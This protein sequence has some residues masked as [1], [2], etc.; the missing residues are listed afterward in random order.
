MEKTQNRVGLDNTL[1]WQGLVS[2]SNLDSFVAGPVNR[3]TI[4]HPHDPRP[5]LHNSGPTSRTPRPSS[6]LAPSNSQDSPFTPTT[7]PAYTNPMMEPPLTS[8]PSLIRGRGRGVHIMDLRTLITDRETTLQLATQNQHSL[9]E[10]RENNPPAAGYWPPVLL[11][12][13]WSEKARAIPMH[14]NCLVHIPDT[15]YGDFWGLFSAPTKKTQ[16]HRETTCL[17][18]TPQNGKML[19]ACLDRNVLDAIR[20]NNGIWLQKPHQMEDPLFL[21]GTVGFRN[22]TIA[23]EAW[24]SEYELPVREEY[25]CCCRK[26]RQDCSVEDVGVFAFG[27]TIAQEVHD[28]KSKSSV[29]PRMVEEQ[30]IQCQAGEKCGNREYH[31]S[32]LGIPQENWQDIALE[33]EWWCPICRDRWPDEARDGVILDGERL[34]LRMRECEPKA[35]KP[36]DSRLFGPQPVAESA[37]HGWSD[38][39]DGG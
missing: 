6:T 1:R 34:E 2:R 14:V 18:E 16:G 23:A 5:R 39:A 26:R 38:F 30:T 17:V 25:V 35:V 24:I 27:K 28:G 3:Q 12:S 8:L 13:K 31:L 15:E 10:L 33:V 11:D 22:W 29:Q 9:I 4:R 36:K 19:W 7:R 20:Y 32:C 37:V 21:P